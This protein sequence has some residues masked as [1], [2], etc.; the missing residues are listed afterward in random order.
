MNTFDTR[1]DLRSRAAMTEFMSTHGRSGL[2]RWAFGS[3]ADKIIHSTA[4]PVLIVTPK[5]CQNTTF[6]A[7]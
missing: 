3:V 2:T 4:T 7:L 1:V 5:D 6:K